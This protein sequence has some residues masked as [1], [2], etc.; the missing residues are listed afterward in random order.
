MCCSFEITLTG[1]KTMEEEA[2]KELALKEVYH[3]YT[4][5]DA[6]ATQL[7]TKVGGLLS[8]SSLILTLFGVLQLN[9]V[10]NAQPKL[11]QELLILVVVLYLTLVVLTLL[12]LI[13]QGYKTVFQENWEGVNKSILQPDDPTIQL[14]ANYL[15]RIKYNKGIND[16]KAKLLKI[17]TIVFALLIVL[18]V[19]MS[20]FVRR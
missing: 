17:A 3:I 10:N 5:Y 18:I 6:D 2:K 15:D 20:L 14:I 8:S 13:P 11:Y 4:R 9:L 12:A 19:I 7:D 1:K 16:R